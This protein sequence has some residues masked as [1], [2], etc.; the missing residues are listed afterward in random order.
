MSDSHTH[1]VG[2]GIHCECVIQASSLVPDFLGR[3]TRVALVKKLLGMIACY[4]WAS[5]EAAD[6]CL[7]AV[8]S[9]L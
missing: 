1:Q 3:R 9:C 8:R 7:C 4:S 5:D 2:N 6:I